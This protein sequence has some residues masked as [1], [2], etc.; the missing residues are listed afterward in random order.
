V[1]KI[2]PPVAKIGRV[3]ML[4]HG[5]GRRNEKRNWGRTR[6]KEGWRRGEQRR[7][8]VGYRDR[9]SVRI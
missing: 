4:F 8:Q 7:G 1:E 6:R 9:S 5:P 3:D 2:N